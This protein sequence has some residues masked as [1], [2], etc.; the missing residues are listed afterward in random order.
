MDAL[1]VLAKMFDDNKNPKPI[2]MST[3]TIISPPPNVQIQLN[4]VVILRNHQLV[5]AANVLED[6]ER[7]AELEGD[8]RFTDSTFQTF[9]AKDVKARTKDTLKEGDEVI[10]MPTADE[11]L[12]YV[13]AKAVRFE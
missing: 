12:Y 11:N 3:G 10:L 5:F 9:E 13:L 7:E 6:Y 4:D 1:T 8:I 2:S